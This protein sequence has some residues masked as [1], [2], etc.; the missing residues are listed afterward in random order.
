MNRITLIIRQKIFSIMFIIIAIIGGIFIY[1]YISNLKARVSEDTE[2]KQ[3]F[4]AGDDIRHGEEITEESIKIQR[5]SENIF[6]EKY[7]TDK[8]KV[9]GKKVM[10]DIME[11]EIITVDKLEGMEYDDGLNSGFSS[12]IPDQLRAVSIPVNFYG[13]KSLISTG[14][15]VDIISTYYEPESRVLYSSTVLSEKEIVLIISDLKEN[16][17]GE[18]YGSSSI[19][20]DSFFDSSSV[21]TDYTNLIILTFYLDVSEAEE[22]FLALERGLLNLSI[23]PV[24]SIRSNSNKVYSNQ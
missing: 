17:S 8:D 22:V 20:A 1:W 15:K 7:I 23:C 5:I 21:N 10:E 6:S 9:L 16:F 3:I 2:Y 14:D 19:L 11:G 12:Y 13:D 24:G 18:E 4:V